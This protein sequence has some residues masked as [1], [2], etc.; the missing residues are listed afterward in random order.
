MDRR[1]Q[2]GVSHIY[3]IRVFFG[4][5]GGE[6]RGVV[7]WKYGVRRN[8]SEEKVEGKVKMEGGRRYSLV[9]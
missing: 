3:I 2:D 1:G 5:G 6:G 8:G 9:E 7:Y 4:C